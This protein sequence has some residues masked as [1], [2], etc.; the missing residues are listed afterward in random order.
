MLPALLSCGSGSTGDPGAAHGG[1]A[2]TGAGQVTLDI[3]VVPPGV[4]CI[5][6][7][8]TGSYTVTQNFAATPDAGTVGSLSLGELPLGSVAITG[9]AYNVACASIASQQPSWVATPQVVTLAPGVVSPLTITFHPDNPV[10]GTP[11][12]VGNV[13]QVAPGYGQLA[14]VF[15]DGTVQVA[16]QVSGIYFAEAFGAF[17]GL[18]NVAQ[19]AYSDDD[20]WGCVLL[21]N[22]T[23]QC[24]GTTNGNGQLGN[25]TT[26]PSTTPVQVTGL[27][28]VM[29]ICA[30]FGHA[31][32]LQSS[33]TVSC[34]G[35]NFDGQLGNNST[36]NSSVPVTASL[37][38]SATSIA[39]GGYHS[40]AIVNAVYANVQCW[41]YNAYGQ[42]GNN[43]TTNSSVGVTANGLGG[44]T[45]LALGF[46]SSCAL[47]ADGSPFCWGYNFDGELGLGNTTNAG[48]P[49][50]VGL[51]GVL[52]LASTLNSACARRSDGTVWC[53]GYDNLGAVGDGTAAV[54]VTSPV[55]VLGALPP[56]ASISAG[57]NTACSLG[58][59]QSLECWGENNQGQL[60]NG[61]VSSA[62]VPTPVRL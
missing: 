17:P 22:G 46:Q 30:G 36:T 4:Q 51:T 52:Q 61:T 9:Q 56:S 33:G 32:A 11:D 1:P 6:I 54:A 40:C 31:C 55:Q 19:Y 41:G 47:R 7:T 5:Q 2:S 45:Q 37:G 18:S 39:C 42:L 50:R 35:A 23:V 29:Q 25:G 8:A 24:F 15:T 34:W 13:A 48:Q 14:V 20:N 12:F 10:T 53:W 27:T 49:A 62:F 43:S 16:G 3:T 60:A 58:T 59:D 44:I 57:N 38:G 21:K 28:S 26:T